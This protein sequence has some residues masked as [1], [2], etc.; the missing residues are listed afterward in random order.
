MPK[1]ATGPAQFRT[2]LRRDPATFLFSSRLRP[3]EPG[4]FLLR[5]L[6]NPPP[7]Q[8]EHQSPSSVVPAQN[9]A[10]LSQGASAGP[11][12]D[13]S[14]R[15]TSSFLLFPRTK[16]GACKDQQLISCCVRSFSDFHTCWR[17][18]FIS[19]DFRFPFRSWQNLPVVLPRK[20]FATSAL[21]CF[22]CSFPPR[23]GHW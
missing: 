22:S 20:K 1:L 15:F 6:Q 14:Q 16:N 18:D 23:P 8:A 7:W 21:N 13:R 10:R 2:V 4:D 9:E 11:P 17:R 19:S 3:P 5:R 12:A